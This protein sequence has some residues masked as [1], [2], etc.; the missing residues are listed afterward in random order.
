MPT[1]ISHSTW[2]NCPIDTVFYFVTNL[3]NDHYWW[4]AVLE[5]KK[6]TPDAVG[7][8]SKFHQHS[9]VL[10]VSIDNHL[11][12]TEWQPPT[13]ARFVNQSAQ[14]AYTVDYICST[15]GGGTRFTLKADLIMKGWLKRF[16][17]LTMNTL[18]RQLDRYFGL[19]KTHLE[20]TSTGQK[21]IH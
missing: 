17:P 5:S 3:E 19:L 6:L 18:H 10:F 15:K 16:F 7:L 4:K 2:I 13:L 8:G 11:Q 21:N 14:L 12:I 1:E 20:A 9:K